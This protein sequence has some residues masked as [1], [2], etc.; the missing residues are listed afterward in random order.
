MT[1]SQ[2]DAEYYAKQFES[3]NEYWQ[4]FGERPN[5]AGRRVLDLGCGHGAM[6]LDAAREGAHVL[7][8]DLDEERVAFARTHVAVEPVAGSLRFETWDLREAEEELSGRFEIVLSKDTLEHI[9]DVPSMLANV[10]DVL[11]PGGQLWAGFSPLYHSPWGDHGRTG[12]RVPWAHSLLPTKMVLKAAARRS[13]HPVSRLY[14]I[15]LNGMTAAEFRRYA[16]DAGFVLRS[17]RYNRGDK[18][19]MTTLARVRRRP[20]LEK[21]ATV[22]IYA[23]LYRPAVADDCSLSA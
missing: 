5:F 11:V 10:Y 7:G 4:R 19:L 8:L 22:G 23:V 12:L 18:P 3:T 9:D 15:G 14:E 16:G 2:T 17:V 6:S 20:R 21:W 13:G 1:Y